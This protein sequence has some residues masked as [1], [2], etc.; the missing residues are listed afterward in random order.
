MHYTVSIGPIKCHTAGTFTDECF[1]TEQVARQFGQITLDKIEQ[2]RNRLGMFKAEQADV[3]NHAM[4]FSRVL[5][6]NGEDTWAMRVLECHSVGC[7]VRTRLPK[8]H[9]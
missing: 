2:G 5:R 8:T 1:T 7:R 9:Q 6:F 4:M 3:E